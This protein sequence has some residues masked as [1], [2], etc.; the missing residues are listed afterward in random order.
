[1]I[2]IPREL[3]GDISLE[4]RRFLNGKVHPRFSRTIRSQAVRISSD[5]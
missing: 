4:Q 5:E 3:I 2:E 1:L